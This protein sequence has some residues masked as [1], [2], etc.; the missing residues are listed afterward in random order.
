[1][2]R[3]YSEW[4]KETITGECKKAGVSICLVDD[5]AI[6]DCDPKWNPFWEPDCSK[7]KFGV[8]RTG[9][10]PPQNLGRRDD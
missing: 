5:V 9:C 2:C 6:S 1:M 4:T 10:V 7:R 3:I 8:G